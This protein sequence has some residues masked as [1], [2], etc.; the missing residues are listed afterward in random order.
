MQNHDGH[1]HF[2]RESTWARLYHHYWWRPNAYQ[3]V[4]KY[5][6]SCSQCQIFDR[7][8]NREKTSMRFPVTHVFERF[9]LD[10]V[11]PLPRTA[12]GNEHL[13]VAMEY[14]T[15]WPIVRACRKADQH[16]TVKFP[17]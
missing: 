12:E 6:Q 1:G 8:S 16:S 7:A 9:A 15:K 10:Y 5:V 2:G 3:D 4:K 14:Y 13:L 11:G 17:L